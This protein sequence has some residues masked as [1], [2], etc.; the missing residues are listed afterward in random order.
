MCSWYVDISRFAQLENTT[1]EYN[2][3]SLKMCYLLCQVFLHGNCTPRVIYNIS[4]TQHTLIWLR[5]SDYGNLLPIIFL[6]NI[7]RYSAFT[8]HFSLAKMTTNKATAMK[9]YRNILFWDLNWVVYRLNMYFIRWRLTV[10]KLGIQSW[11][12]T[13]ISAYHN[14][15]LFLH[16]G[17]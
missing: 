16:C 3:H 15:L 8:I 13:D 5:L 14:S 4:R 12:Q 11:L 10:S 6:S 7:L 1:E 9:H 2:G 17:A